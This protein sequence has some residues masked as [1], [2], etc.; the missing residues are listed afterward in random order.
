M[1]CDHPNKQENRKKIDGDGGWMTWKWGG[2]VGQNLKMGGKQYKV[3]S[4]WNMG[5]STP[6]PTM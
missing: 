5:V 2:G 6:L 4:S 3:W 1:A